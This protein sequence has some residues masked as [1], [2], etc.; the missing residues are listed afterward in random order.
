M[1]DTDDRMTLDGL[2]TAANEARAQTYSPEALPDVPGRGSLLQENQ[3]LERTGT[4]VT[5]VAAFNDARVRYKRVKAERDP[6]SRALMGYANNVGIKVALVL[7]ALAREIDTLDNDVHEV[8][9]DRQA[10]D[11]RR[12][13]KLF[14]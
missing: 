4:S 3:L 13:A 12:A 5:A 6:S 14:R 7:E 11:L 2:E 9:H 10:S 8:D 1:N